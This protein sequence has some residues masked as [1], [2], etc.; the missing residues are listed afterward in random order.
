MVIRWHCLAGH[1]QQLDLA[2]ELLLLLVVV[3]VVPSLSFLLLLLFLLLWRL[4]IHQ[5]RRGHGGQS[6]EALLQQLT[7]ALL[8]LR[9]GVMHRVPG[10]ISTASRLHLDCISAAGAARSR[11]RSDDY[12]TP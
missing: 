3:V 12:H 4:V 9:M 8:R 1:A 7:A 2:A 11:P 5:V 6:G 10:R